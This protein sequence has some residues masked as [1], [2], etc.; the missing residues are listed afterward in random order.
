MN[1]NLYDKYLSHQKGLALLWLW[2]DQWKTVADVDWLD[3]SIE[4]SELL[5]SRFV[6]GAP[7]AKK[8]VKSKNLFLG[9]QSNES[10]WLK[11]ISWKRCVWD[12]ASGRLWL[13]AEQVESPDEAWPDLPSVSVGI[14]ITPPSKL[15]HLKAGDRLDWRGIWWDQD[16]AL[17]VDLAAA[18]SW[19]VREG[20]LNTHWLPNERTH[21]KTLKDVVRARLEKTSVVFDPGFAGQA[22]A[23]SSEQAKFLEPFERQ[24]S[25]PA[26]E[27][28]YPDLFGQFLETARTSP[29]N[30]SDADRKKR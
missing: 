10:Q 4:M 1:Q 30:K 11:R 15:S 24:T 16:N 13:I 2:Y 8:K 12:A 14:L 27:E 23:L 28:R 5:S 20:D 9:V 19:H 18:G 3:N 6:I 26:L 22:P 7:K 17:H 21:V 25:G 29:P